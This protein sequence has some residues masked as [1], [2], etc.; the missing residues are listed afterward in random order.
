MGKG[1]DPEVAVG[2]HHGLSRQALQSFLG[3]GL[4]AHRLG[5]IHRPPTGPQRQAA[6][7]VVEDHDLHHGPVAVA[8]LVSAGRELLDQLR[9]V[10]QGQTGAIDQENGPLQTGPTLLHVAAQLCQDVIGNGHHHQFGQFL[11]SLAKAARADR[12]GS[13]AHSLTAAQQAPGLP[14]AKRLHGSRQSIAG[15]QSLPDHEPDDHHQTVNPRPE[16]ELVALAE[17]VEKCRRRDG[18]KQQQSVRGRGGGHA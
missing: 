16:M 2:H 15:L 5:A 1:E 10:R 6:E 8:V 9:G 18:L 12:N 14:L 11:S 4:F 13:V 17:V 3:Q 7:D